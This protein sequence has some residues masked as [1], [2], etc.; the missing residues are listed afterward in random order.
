VVAEIRECIAMVVLGFL[1]LVGG[2]LSGAANTILAGL[3]ATALGTVF[4]VGY[5]RRHRRGP[6]ALLVAQP[7]GAR[8]RR[9]L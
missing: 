8:S 3:V 1:I 2:A 5:A 9:S 7:Q 6:R 4:L